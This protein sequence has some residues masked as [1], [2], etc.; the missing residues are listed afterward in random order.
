[1]VRAA[2]RSVL[3]ADHTKFGNDLPGPVRRR[4]PTI[5]V[6]ITDT[7][8]SDETATCCGRAGVS[9]SARPGTAAS[10]DGGGA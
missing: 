6:V 8:L 3:L 10:D 1:M 2:E 5:D 7:G 4:W 9:A